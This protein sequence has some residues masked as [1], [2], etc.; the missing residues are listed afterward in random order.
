MVERPPQ[1]GT[2]IGLRDETRAAL[3]PDVAQVG[4]ALCDAGRGRAENNVGVLDGPVEGLGHGG[5]IRK[6]SGSD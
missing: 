3:F 2:R 4:L 5:H 6:A 1:V